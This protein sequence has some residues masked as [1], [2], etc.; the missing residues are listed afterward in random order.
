MPTELRRILLSHAALYWATPPRNLATP[1]PTE[2]HRTL[3]SY[4]APYWAMPHTTEQRR[5][6]LSYAAPY[7]ATPH[8]TEL[9]R[10]FWDTPHPTDQWRYLPIL[11]LLF[12]KFF[13]MIFIHIFSTNNSWFTFIHMVLKENPLV[14][15]EY[16][17]FVISWQAL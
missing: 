3:L 14:F 9:R 5:T 6:L 7:W 12:K 11:F 2:Q 15:D 1:H 10:S 4:T 13:V 16:N 17:F 8:H